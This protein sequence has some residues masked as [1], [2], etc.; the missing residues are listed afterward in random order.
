M[1]CFVG[2]DETYFDNIRNRRED[3]NGRLERCTFQQRFDSF[4]EV[5]E[6]FPNA[7]HSMRGTGVSLRCFDLVNGWF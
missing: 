6:A 4:R 7:C 2:N 3:C 1:R 5:Y